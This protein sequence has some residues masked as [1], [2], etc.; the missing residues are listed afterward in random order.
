MQRLA[1]TGIP[2][3][4]GV[5]HPCFLIPQVCDLALLTV[6]DD[7]FW[8]PDLRPLS[9]VDEPELQVGTPGRKGM[10]AG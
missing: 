3:L 10:V 4:P 6:R 8:S 1:T 2:G 9:F 5:L 7:T